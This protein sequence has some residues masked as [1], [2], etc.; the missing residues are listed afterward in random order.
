MAEL[1]LAEKFQALSI[2]AEQLYREAMELNFKNEGVKD[3][4]SRQSLDEVIAESATIEEY[5]SSADPDELLEN[6][7]VDEREKIVQR[8]ERNE[9]TLK[10]T[11]EPNKK[12]ALERAIE[13]DC[14]YRDMSDA[15][16]K[17][18]MVEEVEKYRDRCASEVKSEILVSELGL[19][20]KKNDLSRYISGLYDVNTVGK[21]EANQIPQLAEL[22]KGSEEFKDW[23]KAQNKAKF[24]SFVGAEAKAEELSSMLDLKA[25]VE[26]LNELENSAEQEIPEDEALAEGEVDYLEAEGEPSADELVNAVEEAEAST[27]DEGLTEADPDMSDDFML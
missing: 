21:I 2:E 12:Q 17:E 13:R 11:S 15:E 22:I 14:A 10:T 6:S 1:T 7:L 24:Y 25:Y 3:K 5:Y 26:I 16:L 20:G 23:V 19:T 8:I 4:E 18:V 27:P 9:E